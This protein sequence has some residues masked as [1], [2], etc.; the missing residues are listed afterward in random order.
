MEST[1]ASGAV[2]VTVGTTRFDDLVEEVLQPSV[3]KELQRRGYLRMIV[4]YGNS[5]VEWPDK[6]GK[7]LVPEHSLIIYLAA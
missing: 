7:L 2:F 1:T 4:Q 6:K 5:E 3:Q